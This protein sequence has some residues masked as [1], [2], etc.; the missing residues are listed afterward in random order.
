[1]AC[2]HSCVSKPISP[3]TG[4]TIRRSADPL[5][6]C[7]RALQLVF[8]VGEAELEA[9]DNEIVGEMDAAYEFADR[10][11]QPEPEARFRNIM[12]GE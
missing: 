1:M 8:D 9:I 7:Q 3:D 12:V 6:R 4:P 2:A 10:S 5:E 11:P